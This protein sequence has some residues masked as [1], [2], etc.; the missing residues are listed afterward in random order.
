M[1]ADSVEVLSANGLNKRFR[2]LAWRRL[3]LSFGYNR[4]AA[5]PSPYQ[6]RTG[7]RYILDSRQSPQPIFKTPIEIEPLCVGRVAVT[8]QAQQTCQQS[9]DIP[10]GVLP[11]TPLDTAQ[12]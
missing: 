6:L 2:K 10:T 8:V 11:G 7:E 3:R 9:V 1:S 5:V 12:E 4:E